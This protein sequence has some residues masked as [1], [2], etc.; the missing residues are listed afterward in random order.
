MITRFYHNMIII[1]IKNHLIGKIILIRYAHSHSLDQNCYLNYCK[2]QL[3]SLVQILLLRTQRMHLN[4]EQ[5][6]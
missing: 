5:S 6:I 1:Q 4:F 3:N 2:S